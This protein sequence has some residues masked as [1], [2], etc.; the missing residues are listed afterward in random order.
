MSS[1]LSELPKPSHLAL[2]VADLAASIAFYRDVLG[3]AVGDLAPNAYVE[4]PG[5]LLVLDVAAPVN[6]EAFHFGFQVSGDG[7]VHAWA[8]RLRE[9]GATI[10]AGPTPRPTLRTPGSVV[11]TIDPDGHKIEIYSGD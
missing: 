6:A 3:L 10:V 2:G 5:F 7:D 11:A 4:W 1:G 8:D 9:R